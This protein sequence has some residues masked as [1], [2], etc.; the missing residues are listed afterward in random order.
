MC[1]LARALLGTLFIICHKTGC[2]CFFI[3]GFLGVCVQVHGLC[4]ENIPS[5]MVVLVLFVASLFVLVTI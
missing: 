5:C 4:L 3:L 1:F 2:R